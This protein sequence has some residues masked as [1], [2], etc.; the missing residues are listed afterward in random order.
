VKN[1]VKFSTPGSHIS[2]ATSNAAT[3]W[4]TVE[5]ADQGI[6][7]EKHLLPLVFDSFQQGDLSG[8]QRND[9]LGLGLYIAKGLA[10]AQ[11]GT[12]TVHSEGR[13]KGA[14]FRLTLPTAPPNP[15]T[16]RQPLTL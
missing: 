16:N 13:G 11:G 12:L 10:E 5:F 3:G 14:M 1:A 4:L 6:G 7:I 2:I 9:G 8:V 15:A